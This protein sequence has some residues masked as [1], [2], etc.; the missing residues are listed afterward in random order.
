MSETGTSKAR[1]MTGVFRFASPGL[2]VTWCCP[3]C[4]KRKT[5]AGRRI[6]FTK[7][8]GRTYVCAECAKELSK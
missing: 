4:A 2:A 3:H 5:T 7:A 6:K 1:D 8:W